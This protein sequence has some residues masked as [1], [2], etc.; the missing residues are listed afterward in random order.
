MPAC[1]GQGSS[2]LRLRC[3]VVR[4]ACLA[5]VRR[6]WGLV[7]FEGH[8]R[9]L[10]CHPGIWNAGADRRSADWALV[11]W[12]RQPKAWRVL[13]FRP[14]LVR[15]VCGVVL[16]CAGSCALSPS[17]LRDWHF[18]PSILKVLGLVAASRICAVSAC[19]R[20]SCRLIRGRD[21]RLLFFLGLQ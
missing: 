8:E 21:V 9:H 19:L 18:I 6:S 1:A 3:G 13:A 16:G 17:S 11:F 7:A 4:E 2:S 12:C 14:L 20:Q 5:P 15:G 10:G